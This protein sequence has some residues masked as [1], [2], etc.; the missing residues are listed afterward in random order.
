MAK[1]KVTILIALALLIGGCGET[2]P[3]ELPTRE[4]AIPADAVKMTRD[5]D[6]TPPVL[7]SDEYE[8]P[9]PLAVINTAGAEDSPFI[10]AGRNDL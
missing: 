1:L 10:P 6:V 8:I 7:H 9:V 3:E 4:S 2:E 5:M